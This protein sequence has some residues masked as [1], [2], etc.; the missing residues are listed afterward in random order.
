MV[1]HHTVHHTVYHMVYDMVLDEF[2][3]LEL[4]ILIRCEQLFSIVLS[5]I[6]K[7]D[8]IPPVQPLATPYARP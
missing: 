1:Y 8:Q 2:G 6:I 5:N 7:A 4:D 3:L